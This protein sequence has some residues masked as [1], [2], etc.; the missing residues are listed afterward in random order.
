MGQW[1]YEIFCYWFA[2]LYPKWSSSKLKIKKA[3][4]TKCQLIK[5]TIP[6]NNTL[7]YLQLYGKNPRI[8][9]KNGEYPKIALSN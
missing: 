8:P 5:V 6:Q 7:I 1:F 4:A 3:E 9:N 2:K